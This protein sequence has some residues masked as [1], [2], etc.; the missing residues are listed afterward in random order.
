MGESCRCWALL[1]V[2]YDFDSCE[3]LSD[4]RR[5]S[6]MRA[7]C[8]HSLRECVSKRAGYFASAITQTNRELRLFVSFFLKSC[9]WPSLLA[10]LA[11][12]ALNRCSL[13][14]RG[15]SKDALRAEAEANTAWGRL[16]GLQCHSYFGQRAIFDFGTIVFRAVLPD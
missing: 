8:R 16:V 11:T 12:V 4:G 2:V 6:D 10:Q 14:D 5:P 3:V 13:L 1:E 9:S 15:R 7:T